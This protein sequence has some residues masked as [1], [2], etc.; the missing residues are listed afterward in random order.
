MSTGIKYTYLWYTLSPLFFSPWHWLFEFVI[1][2]FFNKENG[3]LYQI[4]CCFYEDKSINIIKSFHSGSCYFIVRKHI[5]K[6][7][8]SSIFV[9]FVNK[10]LLS[11]AK[12]HCFNFVVTIYLLSFIELSTEQ[13][14]GPKIYLKFKFNQLLKKISLKCALVFPIVTLR[15][16]ISYLK[17]NVF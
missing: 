3:L 10:R 2:C 6:S 15:Y 8:F 5:Q 12:M 7:V 11:Y 17:I 9:T 1:L 4:L 13:Q 14:R 16:V